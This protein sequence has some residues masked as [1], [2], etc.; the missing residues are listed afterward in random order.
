MYVEFIEPVLYF[1]FVAKSIDRLV[2]R[3][4]NDDCKGS[5]GEK[6]KATFK[7]LGVG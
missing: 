6:K 4:V 1:G 5:L 2:L 7:Y 3:K